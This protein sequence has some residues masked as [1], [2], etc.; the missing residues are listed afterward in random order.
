MEISDSLN[1]IFILLASF[2]FVASA[3][4]DV[5]ERDLHEA[6]VD[7]SLEEV[8]NSLKS[9][10][11]YQINMHGYQGILF[12]SIQNEIYFLYFRKPTSS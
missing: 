5:S 12:N 1:L 9:C 4:S 3:S 6:V 10:Y 7:G 2:S 8:I 11:S